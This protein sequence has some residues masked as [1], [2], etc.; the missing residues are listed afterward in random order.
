[1]ST[2]TTALLSA[3]WLADNLSSPNIHVV[4][5]S[6]YLLAAGR[7]AYA[8]FQAT[9]I[10]GAVFF[11]ID[12]IADPGSGLPHMLPT[13][14]AF[15]MLMGKLGI[16][17]GSQVVV[18]D[19]HGLM[20]AARAWWMFRVFG[21]QAVSVLD[22][23]LPGWTAKGYPV[24]SASSDSPP[25]VP[26]SLLPVRRNDKLVRS[27]DQ[28]RSNVQTRR[29]QLVDARSAGRFTGVDPEP[30]AGLRSGHV[31]GALNLPFNELLDAESGSMRAP[32]FVRAAFESVGVD[33][34]RPVSACCGSG[35]TAC[36]LALGLY[37][38]GRTDAA[39]YDGSWAEWGADPDLPI[40]TG[41]GG[42]TGH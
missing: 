39:V 28:V 40:A 25:E 29:E 2:A 10:P 22:A 6:W 19:G 34:A 7:D 17:D 3:Q 8:E 23:G 13:A 27:L 5:A 38:I 4:D 26:A 14:K 16:G 20:S 12:A 37:T 9:H 24:Q 15:S 1:M 21:H 41:T 33:L 32:E 30:R 31:P 18:Y 42:L 35:I 36:V 11:D